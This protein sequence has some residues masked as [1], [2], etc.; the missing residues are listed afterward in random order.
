VTRDK[1]R[2]AIEHSV[3]MIRCGRPGC[4]RTGGEALRKSIVGQFRLLWL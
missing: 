4:K 1:F 2:D 3:R